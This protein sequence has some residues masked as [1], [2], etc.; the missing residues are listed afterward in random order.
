[1]SAQT[2]TIG[3]L[4]VPGP[5]GVN[6]WW[7]EPEAGVA[8]IDLQ[9]DPRA[10]ERAIEAVRAL[11]KPVYA[12]LLTHAHPDHIGGAEAF[13]RAFPRAPLCATRATDREIR[14]D[15]HGFQR[16]TREA[17]GAAAPETYPPADRILG[18][19]ERLVFWDLHLEARELGPGEAG[20]AT[21]Y[22]VKRSG[23]LFC[24]DV[25]GNG[26]IPFLLEGRSGAWLAQLDR[27]EAE[28][29]EA[30]R[31]YPGH[32]DPG[33]PA[34]LIAGQRRYLERLRA[35]VERQITEGHWDG[36]SLD[37]SGRRAVAGA[38]AA[39]Y[40]EAVPVA[41]IPDLAEQNADAVA[42]ELMSDNGTGASI[43]REAAPH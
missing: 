11:G 23:A 6:T 26:V 40:P 42:R 4:T 21:V 28:F 33:S 41:P 16:L 39:E 9:R 32:G 38:M 19:R 17:L 15:P 34:V 10:A 12:L 14:L 43:G 2:L 27:L 35:E 18:E 31:L 29:P 37:A 7:V 36:E 30:E 5:G 24:G 25:V 3:R 20:S 1:M 22:W 8:V 13:R